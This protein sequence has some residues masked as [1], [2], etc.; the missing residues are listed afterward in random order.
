MP[1]ADAVPEFV[2]RLAAHPDRTGILTD[3]DGTLA[4][5]VPN[6]PDAQ[7]VA[8]AVDVLHRLAG[9]YRVVAVVSGRPARFLV[10]RL[11]VATRPPSALRAIGAYGLERAEGAEVVPHPDAERWCPAVDSVAADALEQAPPGVLVEHKTQSLTIHVRTAPEHE[12][13]ARSFVDVAAADTGLVVHRARMSFELRPPLPID[14]GSTVTS[15]LAGLDAACFF[16]DDRGDL[17]A[18][19]ALERFEA[20]G[21][22][23]VK[24]AVRSPEAPPE[25]IARADLIVDGPDGTVEFLRRLL[26]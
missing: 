3:F 10:E 1:A 23:A 24:V 17:P 2:R 6:P 19:D 25:L 18:F 8:G 11:E 16:G 15:L 22:T 5:I 4:A 7:A 12:A 13:W 21:G 26:P 9:C 20:D 14:K